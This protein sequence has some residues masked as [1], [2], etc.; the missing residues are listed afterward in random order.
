MFCNS[1]SRQFS[2]AGEEETKRGGVVGAG[3]K[4]LGLA[5]SLILLEKP[6]NVRRNHEEHTTADAGRPGLGADRLR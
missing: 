6:T 4:Q 1:E 3:Y 2:G 5:Q